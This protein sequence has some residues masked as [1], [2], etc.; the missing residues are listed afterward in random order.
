MAL[1]LIQRLPVASGGTAV[2]ACVLK[3]SNHIPGPVTPMLACMHRITKRVL[4]PMKVCL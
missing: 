4:G 2:L 3:T 1:P